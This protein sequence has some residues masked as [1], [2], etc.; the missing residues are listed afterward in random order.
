VNKKDA[1]EKVAKL[2][3]VAQGTS[4]PNEADTARRQADKLASDHGLT[5]QDLSSG[6]MAA[7]FDALV[8]EVEKV[9]SRSAIPT[10]LFGTE[11]VI[12]DVLGKIRNFREDDK[13]KKLR[14]VALV[15]KVGAMIAG[16]NTTVSEIKTV[17]DSVLKNHGLTSVF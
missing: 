4:N 14:Q 9:V 6:Q 2:R 11:S 10:G 12:K 3:R 13:A 17:L 15:I 7:A 1:A 5:E 8:E 16:N